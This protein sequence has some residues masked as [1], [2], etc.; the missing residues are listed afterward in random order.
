[1]VR[2]SPAVNNDYAYSVVE[3]NVSGSAT[4]TGTMSL[5]GTVHLDEAAGTVALEG[6]GAPLLLADVKREPTN[7]R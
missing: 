2:A 6:N 1:M 7:A 5:A 3:L 4:G